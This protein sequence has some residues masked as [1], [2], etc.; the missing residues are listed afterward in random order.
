ME[1]I[2]VS[3]EALAVMIDWQVGVGQRVGTKA[4]F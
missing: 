1:V 4:D 3:S 2:G